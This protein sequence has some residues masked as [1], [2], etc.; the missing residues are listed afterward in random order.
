MKNVTGPDGRPVI[1]AAHRARRDPEHPTLPMR[2]A[3]STAEAFRDSDEYRGS[4]EPQLAEPERKEPSR[5]Y[6]KTCD[7]LC[8]S[9]AI[10]FVVWVL[11]QWAQSLQLAHGRLWTGG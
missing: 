7:A 9:G 6:L 8:W 2:W 3:R 5:L 11:L 10:G 4:A 1:G